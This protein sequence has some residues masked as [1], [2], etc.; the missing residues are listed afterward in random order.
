MK[1]FKGQRLT[2]VTLEHLARAFNEIPY[3]P[4]RGTEAWRVWDNK[5]R[6]STEDITH[7]LDLILGDW[8][9]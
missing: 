8:R 1:L 4:P 7:Y 2:V 6:Y 3:Y 5:E 9:R